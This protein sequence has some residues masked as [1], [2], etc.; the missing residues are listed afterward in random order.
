MGSVCCVA[1]KKRT[2][3]NRT[4][5]ETLCRNAIRSP[6]W[7][8]QWD[9]RQRVS[10]EIGTPYQVSRGI[11]TNDS[12]ELKGALSSE[13]GNFSDLGSPLEN[14]GT[15]ISQKSPVHGGTGTNLSPSPDISIARNY[16]P[17]VKSLTE[18]LA[19]AN[20]FASNVSLSMPTNFSTPTAEP[21]RC[22]KFKSKQVVNGSC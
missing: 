10:S 14:F 20:S 6:S 12:M 17:D 16:S 9:N 2:H 15:P 3:P 13:R 7:N 4:E 8:F 19:I 5:G 1:A 11:S 22:W 18:S 21:S